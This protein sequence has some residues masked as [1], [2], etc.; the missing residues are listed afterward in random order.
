MAAATQPQRQ[1]RKPN[2]NAVD[3]IAFASDHTLKD[4]HRLS[5]SYQWPSQ[6]VSAWEMKAGQ[7]K[8]SRFGP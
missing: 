5:D 4:S 8:T 7:V 3:K 6:L 2:S 1:F